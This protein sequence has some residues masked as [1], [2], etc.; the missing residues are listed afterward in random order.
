MSDCTIDELCVTHFERRLSTREQ[1]E[2]ILNCLEQLGLINSFFLLFREKFPNR[3]TTHLSEA[4][5]QEIILDARPMAVA[6][7]AQTYIAESE[8]NDAA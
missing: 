4:E 3:D 6:A 8:N 2:N 1:L 7:L 5:L